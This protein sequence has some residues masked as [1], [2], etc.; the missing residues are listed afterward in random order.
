MPRERKRHEHRWLNSLSAGQ[1]HKKHKGTDGS[2][3]IWAFVLLF[4]M[5]LSW[6][7]GADVPVQVF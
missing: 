1:S 2:K 7:A 6:Q 5:L 3:T 4:V